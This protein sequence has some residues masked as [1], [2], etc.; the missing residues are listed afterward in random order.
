MKTYII[1]FVL[2]IPA[3][4][5]AGNPVGMNQG[6]M[7]NMMQVMQQVQQC[8]EKI[9]Q[10]K[11]NELQ[12]RSEKLKQEVDTLCAQGK[13]DKAQEKAL[14]FGKEI[15]S[16]PAIQQMSKCGELAQ[17]AL[18]MMSNINTYDEKEYANKHVCDE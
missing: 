2:L 17:G 6:N 13:R 12:A 9:D 8:M 10:S 3:A 5:I 4:L 7:Q 15:A 16:D 14:V 11:L 18:P 1:L